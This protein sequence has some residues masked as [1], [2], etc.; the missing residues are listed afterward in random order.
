MKKR[1]KKVRWL[2][3]LVVAVYFFLP[4]PTVTEKQ[5]TAIHEQAFRFLYNSEDYGPK[6]SVEV[7]YIDI[8][9]GNILGT[10]GF[11]QNEH[12]LKLRDP[13]ESLMTALVDWPTV[14]KVGSEFPQIDWDC[15][16]AKENQE[17]IQNTVNLAAGPILKS[18][19][20]ARCRTYYDGGPLCAAEYESL[21]AWTPFGW[22]H[23]FSIQL[24]VS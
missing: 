23:L 24:W 13:D 16:E 4:L 19:G 15:P 21:F 22:K 20:L 2:L 14:V 10:F 18:L 17:S 12:S 11:C 6:E 5:A 3:G 8:G 7:F 1:G 9:H